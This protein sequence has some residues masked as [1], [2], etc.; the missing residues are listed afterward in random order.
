MEVMDK[1]LVVVDLTPQAIRVV[2]VV[3]QQETLNGLVLMVVLVS[4][5]WSGCREDCT[6]Q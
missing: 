6:D 1:T 3:V 4:A 5:L 2:G